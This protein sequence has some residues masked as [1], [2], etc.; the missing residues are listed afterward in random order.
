M[1][2]DA[3]THIPAHGMRPLQLPTHTLTEAF[4]IPPKLPGHV[5]HVCKGKLPGLSLLPARKPAVPQQHEGSRVPL[6]FLPRALPKPQKPELSYFCLKN[7]GKVG[8]VQ[9]WDGKTAL[10]QH[11]CHQESSVQR[12]SGP[13]WSSGKHGR[14]SSPNLMFADSPAAADTGDIV[15]GADMLRAPQQFKVFTELDLASPSPPCPRPGPRGHSCKVEP[16]KKIWEHDISSPRHLPF[17]MEASQLSQPPQETPWHD[18]ALHPDATC[19]DKSP[20]P[21]P[22]PHWS[23]A[24]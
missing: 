4:V 6:L 1:L 9:L 20:Q 15:R 5:W 19:K 16:G 11:D 17:P 7:R 23:C 3:W 8:E 12:S 21:V 24:L 2:V 22:S 14:L 18:T 10:P 13:A